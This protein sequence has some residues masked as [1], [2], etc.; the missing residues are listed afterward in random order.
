MKARFHDFENSL[1]FLSITLTRLI[2]AH[3]RK[4]LVEASIDLT[5][6]QW[7]VLAYL[8]NEGRVAQDELATLVCVDKSSLSRVLDVMERRGLVR[9]ERDP[10]D[11]RKKIL[12][13][14]PAAKEYQLPSR[15]VVMEM[16]QDILKDCKP[17]DVETCLRVIKQVKT[18]LKE[19]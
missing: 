5:A 13:A 6:E 8:W 11:A 4:R 2:S 17:E 7:G 1:G 10:D 19:L 14:L 16:T 9:R 3:F 12:Y 18:T 15:E